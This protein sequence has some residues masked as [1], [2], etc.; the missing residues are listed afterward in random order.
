MAFNALN[1]FG[2]SL[3]KVA[4]NP[5][6][7]KIAVSATKFGLGRANN[8]LKV[9]FLSRSVWHMCAKSQGMKKQ[10][11]T[12][13]SPSPLG[14]MKSCNCGTTSLH[15]KGDQELVQFLTDEIASEVKAQKHPKLPKIE[16]FDV[17]SDQ[18]SVHLTKKM[19]EET[20]TVKLNVNHTVDSEVPEAEANPNADK[21]ELGEMKAKP[22][23]TVEIA[24]GNSVLG[25]TCSYVQEYNR[26]EGDP[27]AYNDIFNID[28]V[29]FHG[30]E[31][32]EN[33][34]AVSG[35]IIDGYLYDLL[36]NLLE[37]RG[38]SSEFAEKLVEFTTSYEHKLYISLLENLKS[39]VSGGK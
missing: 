32:K 30:G 33:T 14:W 23:F 16:G 1:T 13:L 18:A 12:K 35:E 39:F 29:V 24:K 3:V 6:Q 36:M 19:G 8:G 25:F 5:A 28:E 7:T 21:P 37:E 20:I 2:R 17:K 34:Y 22:S 38:I 10:E 26:E 31:W 4:A 11:M 9:G 15:T 27:D